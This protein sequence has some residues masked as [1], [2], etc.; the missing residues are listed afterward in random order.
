MDLWRIN[1]TFAF[2]LPYCNC[3]PLNIVRVKRDVSNRDYFE[4]LQVE[5]IPIPRKT[6][7]KIIIRYENR[8]VLYE[9]RQDDFVRVN[10][11]D[12]SRVIDNDRV[13]PVDDFCLIQNKT[14]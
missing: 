9:T 8:N 13:I 12:S 10:K 7:V 11:E 1:E 3:L 4:Y 5:V 14:N 2:F 6:F